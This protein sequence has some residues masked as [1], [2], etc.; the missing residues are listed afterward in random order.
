MESSSLVVLGGI[1]LA[2]AVVS[3]RLVGTSLTAAMVFVGAGFV[4][5]TEGLDW[6]HGSYGEHAISVLAEATLVVVL[7]TDAARINLPALRREY[8]VPARLL[9][10][11]LPLTIVAGTIAAL[12]VFRD[13]QWAEAAVLAIVL[14]PT[15]AAL[16]QAV[17]TDPALPS[18]IR[19]GLNVESGLNDG[20]CVPF[21]TI[22]L[23]IAQTD[24][25]ET[26]A[27]HATKL[28]FEA[29]GWGIAGGV[30]AGL[31]AAYAVRWARDHAS[32]ESHWIQVVP[33]IAAVGAYGMADAYGGSGFIAAFVGGVVFGRLAHQD[34]STAAFS[35]E[36]GGV[37][38]GVTFIVFGAV[39]LG[40][41]WSHIGVAEIFY[42]LV[43]LTV[44][45]MVPVA[46]AMLS[47]G[48]RPP[49]VLFLGWF[50]PRGLASI[51][52]GVVVVEAG[53]LPHTST[54]VTVITVTVALSVIVH[55]V[56]A[57]PLARRYAAWHD[58]ARAPMESKATEH[59]RWR[60]AVPDV[61]RA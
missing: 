26:T 15:D 39:V 11:G 4:F 46:I 37:L 30:V 36:L 6:L 61:S 23:A 10:I 3:R 54:L 22:A 20:L 17:V 50:G 52:F 25:G 18:R 7:F 1:F 44:V 34:E 13:L 53:G 42:A 28:V 5:G 2:Y 38:N 9:G 24:T 16:G 12:V 40:A 35:E 32:I 21:L 59:Q 58:G 49:T 43:S 45:R 47:S 51:V 14:A 29:I 57:A 8:S 41:Q 19:Q 27:A 56:T 55:G 31:V 33:V 60:H 48:A